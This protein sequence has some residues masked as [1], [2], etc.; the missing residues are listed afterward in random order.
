MNMV[1]GFTSCFIEQN[2]Q[3]SPD[4]VDRG[5]VRVLYKITLRQ[6]EPETQSTPFPHNR[7]IQ[8]SG[9]AGRGRGVMIDDREILQYFTD[10]AVQ[11]ELGRDNAESFAICLL[12]EAA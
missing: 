4:Q 5:V 10:R 2:S 11:P 7:Q 6:D 12:G 3:C 8:M 9:F 1:I